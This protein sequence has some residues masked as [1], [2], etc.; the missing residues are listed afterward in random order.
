MEITSYAKGA[1]V[2]CEYPNGGF[3]KRPMP[4]H[5][6]MTNLRGPLQVITNSGANYSLRDEATGRIV[7]AH[8]SRLT[9]FLYDKD[10]VDPV[11]IAAKDSDQYLVERI[12]NHRGYTGTGASN[13]ISKLW[14]EVKW[15][16]FEETDWQQWTGNLNKNIRAHDYMR[17]FP[18]LKKHIGKH[19]QDAHEEALRQA[20]AEAAPAP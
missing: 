9:P 19:F 20:Q 7:Q 6:L 4:P 14:L 10:R 15:V 3:T 18:Y 5:K 8:V 13:K 16:G 11:A 17:Q 1:Y 12:V 2:L